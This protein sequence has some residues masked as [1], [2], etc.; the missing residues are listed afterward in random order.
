[1]HRAWE[2]RL[3]M[4]SMMKLA[5]AEMREQ[6]EKACASSKTGT[7]DILNHIFLRQV[8][9]VLY[10]TDKGIVRDTHRHYIEGGGFT[11]HSMFI[12]RLQIKHF[13]K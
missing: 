10:L 5:L 1:M 2:K 4:D 6:V 8:Y 12:T 9:T 13:L 7:Y 3:E 11:E